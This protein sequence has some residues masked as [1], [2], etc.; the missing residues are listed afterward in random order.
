MTTTITRHDDYQA[1][2]YDI[3]AAELRSQLDHAK[4]ELLAALT[5]CA[6]WNVCL[7]PE[8]DLN[9]DTLIDD[10]HRAAANPFPDPT[11]SKAPRSDPVSG[12]PSAGSKG[13]N[14]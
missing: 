8:V 10:I 11:P 2:G 5:A 3:A 14:H 13:G 9:L 7:S 1:D 12:M 4:D 6:E